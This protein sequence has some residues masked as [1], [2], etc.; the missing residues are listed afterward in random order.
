MSAINHEYHVAH[1]SGGGDSGEDA[2]YKASYT[3]D[4][5]DTSVNLCGGDR[6]DVIMAIHNHA[7]SVKAEKYHVYGVGGPIGTSYL[8]GGIVKN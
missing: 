2:Y 8:K 1:K 7:L 4:S 5:G 3:T 6:D